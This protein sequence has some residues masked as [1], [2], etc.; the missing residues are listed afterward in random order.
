M[1]SSTTIHTTAIT[2]DCADVKVLASFWAAVAGGTVGSEATPEFASLERPGAVNF[3]FA[4]VPEGKTAKNRVHLD[5]TIDNL[6]A[7]V[8]SATSLGAE[9]VA[10]Q[11]GWTVLRDP[12][13]NEFCLVA[14]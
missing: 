13:G 2:F 3:S 11:D 9:V 5:I 10:Q 12:E 1:T 8:V 4:Q 14:S 6:A 7:A